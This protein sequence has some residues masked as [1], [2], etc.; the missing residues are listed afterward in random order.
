MWID[1]QRLTYNLM[2]KPL[3]N[4]FWLTLLYERRILFTVGPIMYR[5]II[6]KLSSDLTVSFSFMLGWC[7][8]L[9]WLISLENLPCGRTS[10]C[11][12]TLILLAVLDMFLIIQNNAIHRICAETKG[13]PFKVTFWNGFLNENC[14]MLITFHVHQLTII[15]RW[16]KWWNRTEQGNKPQ[17]IIGIKI[18]LS[19]VFIIVP[20]CAQHLT[21]GPLG[22]NG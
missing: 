11:L 5:K 10:L 20:H 22:L 8:T 7:A 6:S 2:P 15:Y 17:T 4:H 19:C 21:Y 12:I 9:P 3:L 1:W 14:C 13:T 18:S 16:F